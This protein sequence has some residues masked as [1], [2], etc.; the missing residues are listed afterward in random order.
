MSTPAFTLCVGGSALHLMVAYGAAAWTM[1]YFIRFHHLEVAQ[2]ALLI[3]G[4]GAATGGVGTVVGGF[5]GDRLGARDRR[6]LAW[7]PALTVLAA[8]GVGAS[9]FL[10]G[11]AILGVAGVAATV[12]L[13][14]LY[15]PATYAL[16][17]SVAHADE[18]ATAAGLMI[19]IQNLVGLG[20]GPLAVGVMSDHLAAAYG[21]R[22]LG[23]A[24]ALLF[25]L[26]IGAAAAYGLSGKALGR[27]EGAKQSRVPA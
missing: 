13:N 18:R 27:P 25:V 6:W 19:F 5:V 15:Q 17:Q 4:L 23:I 20:L 9:A 7:W 26:N 24:L 3:G 16:V 1:A 14:A 12:F 11:S 21:P 22:A 8:A 10:T 2:A